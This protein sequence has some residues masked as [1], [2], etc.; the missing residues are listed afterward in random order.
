MKKSYLSVVIAMMCLLVMGG[1]AGAQ[2]S[3]GIVASVPI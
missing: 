2:D 1:A 3:E